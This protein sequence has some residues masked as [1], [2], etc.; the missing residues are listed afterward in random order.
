[1][2][3]YKSYLDR[4]EISQAAHE[5]L[6]NLEVG[7]RSARPWVKYGALAACAALIIGVGAWRLAPAPAANPVQSDN[8]FAADHTPLPGDTDVAEPGGSFVVKNRT[9]VELISPTIPGILYQ[10]IPDRPQADVCRAYEPGSFMVDLTK[11]DIQTIF[12]GLKAERPKTE[13]GDLPWALFWDGYTLRGRAL[14]DGQGQLM[15]LTVWGEKDQASFELEMRLGG[16]PFTCC[17]DMNRGDQISEFN[18]VEIAGW[19]RVYDRDGDS[20][21]DYICGSEF[22][23]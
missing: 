18:G 23:T 14:Y 3:N 20:Q 16:L 17:I 7:K 6:L 12:W 22:M 9:F 13:E 10:D 4:Q 2:K 5:N 11:E 19:S 1:M 21:D 8:Q 15:E